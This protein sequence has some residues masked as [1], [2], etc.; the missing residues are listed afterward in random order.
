MIGRRLNRNRPDIRSR[1]RKIE[2]V[3]LDCHTRVSDGDKK[4]G[5]YSGSWIYLFDTRERTDMTS[6]DGLASEL[7]REDPKQIE[8]K[9]NGNSFPVQRYRRSS[10]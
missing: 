8:G 6:S 1:F 7:R 3:V 2:G 5:F 9:S 4:H 10:V